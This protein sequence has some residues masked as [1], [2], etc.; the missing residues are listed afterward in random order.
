MPFV[1]ELFSI[2]AAMIWAFAVLLLRRAGETVHPFDLNLYRVGVSSVLMVATMV[3]AGLPLLPRTSARDYVLLGLS[4]A[5]G[6]AL[7]DTLLHWSLNIVGAGINAIVDCVYSP[8]VAL[9]A[10]AFL[11]ER[12]T[13]LQ[14]LGMALVLLAILST[15]HAKPPTGTSPGRLITG[16]LIGVLAMVTLAAG[17][18]LAK[19]VLTRH[20]VLWVVTARQLF[21]LLL[22]GVAAGISPQRTRIWRV[23][24]PRPDWR[25]T[26][27]ATV[28]GSYLALMCWLAGMKLTT[29]GTAAVLNQ[30]S[31]IFILVFAAIFLREP[32]T[33]RRV[34][35]ALLALAGIILVTF[36]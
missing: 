27:P 35:A 32:F 15:T 20:S 34:V 29:A 31:T 26:F 18:V 28:L 5:I 6:I 9:I 13:E 10:F 12:L 7:S 33:L 8:V 17:V 22:L 30:T 1:G 25:F 11:G 36:G 21:S 3:A 16:I 19:P 14:L 4:A 23:F 2:A 24:R